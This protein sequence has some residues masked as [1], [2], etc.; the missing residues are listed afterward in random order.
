MT[1]FDI[2]Q[3]PDCV[4]PK[5]KRV[6]KLPEESRH[7][8][9]DLGRPQTYVSSLRKSVGALFVPLRQNSPIKIF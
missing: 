9:D 8:E 4:W 6:Q 5:I 3:E 7:V 1:L 2:G